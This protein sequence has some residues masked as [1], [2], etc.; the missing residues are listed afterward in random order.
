MIL[1][2]TEKLLLT[3]RKFPQMLIDT[4]E[5]IV[6]L[7]KFAGTDLTD[8][9]DSRHI[10]RSIPADGQHIDYLVR[11]GDTILFLEAGDVEK[12]IVATL[13]PGL[14][15]EDMRLEQLPVI[16][17]GGHHIHVETSPGTALGH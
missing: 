4:L 15:L 17:V 12:L 10:I 9:L 1:R 11:A 5:G 13:L 14:D 2:S 8:A 7:Q 3:G 16:L 6:L